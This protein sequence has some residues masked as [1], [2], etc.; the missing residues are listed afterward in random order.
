MKFQAILAHGEQIIVFVL[1]V[2]AGAVVVG[3]SGLVAA[4]RKKEGEISIAG[5]ICAVLGII[6]GAFLCFLHGAEPPFFDLLSLVML[7][8]LPL[9][10]L[11]LYLSF[12]RKGNN[13]NRR[14]IQP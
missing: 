6:V 14:W 12:K 8:P 5:A 10:I 7:L 11:A 1:A 4:M 3:V 9:S 13:A 2:G